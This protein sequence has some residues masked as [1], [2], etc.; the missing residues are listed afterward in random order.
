MSE[1]WLDPCVPDCAVSLSGYHLY[2]C[3]RSRSGGGIGAYVAEYLSC[4]TLS[5]SS[6]ISSHG[7]ET[8]WLSISSFHSSKACFAFGCF[9]RP[10]NLPASS[11]DALCMFIEA[12]LVFHKHVVVCGDQ[13]IDSLDT[14]HTF[15]KCHQNVILVLSYNSSHPHFC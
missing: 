4:T 10:P 8:L 14:D 6:G 11:V 1:S 13:N 15:T 2:C 12:M 7:L 3:D 9:Y 5:H